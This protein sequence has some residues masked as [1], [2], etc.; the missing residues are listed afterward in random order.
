MALNEPAAGPVEGSRGTKGG[1]GT[2]DKDIV[3]RTSQAAEQ[4]KKRK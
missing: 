1:T 2:I 4:R 3:R